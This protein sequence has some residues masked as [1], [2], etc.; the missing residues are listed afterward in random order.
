MCCVKVVRCAISPSGKL[1][2]TATQDHGIQ[3][4]ELPSGRILQDLTVSAPPLFCRPSRINGSDACS[5]LFLLHSCCILSP[6]PVL[7]QPP[8]GEPIL[9]EARGCKITMLQRA[10]LKARSALQGHGD[11]ITGLSFSPDSA[12]VVS[13]SR[14]CSLRV[15]QVTTGVGTCSLAVAWCI[16]QCRYV[17][18]V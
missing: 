12:I 5:I 15:W 3:I 13:S 1:A 17:C 2:A 7:S 6:L 4:W 9:E 10:L 14:D 16:L 18:A 8:L 11:D